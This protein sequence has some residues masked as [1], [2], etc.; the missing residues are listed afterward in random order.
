M[1]AR[2]RGLRDTFTLTPDSHSIKKSVPF[3][4]S[5]CHNGGPKPPVG[6][7]RAARHLLMYKGFADVG[8]FYLS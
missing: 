6:G 7:L 1:N 4:A 2:Y 5:P 8:R 3:V